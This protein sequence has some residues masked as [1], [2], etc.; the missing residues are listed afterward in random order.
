MVEFPE[1]RILLFC[2]HKGTLKFPGVLLPV[3]TTANAT[4]PHCKCDNTVRMG[5]T[6]GKWLHFCFGCG[7]RFELKIADDSQVAS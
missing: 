1:Y 4:C 6:V 3:S 7:K 2:R 5:Q